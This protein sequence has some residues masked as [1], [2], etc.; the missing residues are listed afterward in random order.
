MKDLSG[1]GCNYFCQF[2]N[3]IQRLKYSLKKEGAAEESNVDFEIGVNAP[4]AK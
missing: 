2:L 3:M 4:A 1:N